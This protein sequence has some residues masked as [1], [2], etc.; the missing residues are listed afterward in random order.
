[1]SNLYLFLF[2]FF[3][4]LWHLVLFVVILPYLLIQLAQGLDYL[5]F[6][7]LLN[8]DHIGWFA[9]FPTEIINLAALVFAAFGLLVIIEATITLYQDAHVFPFTS[10]PHEEMTP[11]QLSTGGWYARVRHPMAF[12][13]LL[14]LVGLAVFFR[15]PTL[16]LWWVPILAV[17]LLE[18][19]LLVEE[20]QLKQWFGEDYAK[21]QQRVPPLIPRLWG[22]LS[23]TTQEKTPTNA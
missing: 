12:G 15:S 5:I 18:Y 1:M 7:N 4:Y 14:T 13:Y 8:F 20:K 21:Y 2:Q 10:L 23:R 17:G 22:R 9:A 6:V 11:A 19:A 16:L 3:G